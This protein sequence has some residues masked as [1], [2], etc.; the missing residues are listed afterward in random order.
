MFPWMYGGQ[1]PPPPDPRLGAPTV[2][3]ELTETGA[4][5]W[6][7]YPAQRTQFIADALAWASKKYH[8]TIVRIVDD[9]GD[10]L[11]SQPTRKP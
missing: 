8:P 2:D 7:A 9:K 11:H 10:L 1:P 5:L 6:R 3:Y 4:K